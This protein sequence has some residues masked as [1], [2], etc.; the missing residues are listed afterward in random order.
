MTW[1][2]AASSRNPDALTLFAGALGWLA[3]ARGQPNAELRRQ[4]RVSAHIFRF[5][6]RPDGYRPS[7]VWAPLGLKLTPPG[8]GT[9]GPGAANFQA[10]I[11]LNG[12]LIGRYIDNLGPQNTFY[13][14][15]GLLR[16]DGDNTLAI[17]EWS[18]APGAGRTGPTVAVAVRDRTRGDPGA[19]RGEPRLSGRRVTS[20]A[21]PASHRRRQ[22]SYS[23]ESPP[24][25]SNPQPLH[26]KF[27]I[28]RAVAVNAGRF[29][30]VK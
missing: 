12:W 7:G 6:I 22:L 26:Y 13:L 5:G 21:V 15:Q 3:A 10:L 14:P 28:C 18:L 19:R 20:R 4:R 8:G 1:G 23:G 9:P 16:I 11:Y 30:L 29:F 24:G 27:G 2:P 25:D 17:A